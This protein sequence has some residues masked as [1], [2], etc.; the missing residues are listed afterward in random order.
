MKK[1]AI[2]IW[3][4]NLILLSIC[5]VYQKHSELKYTDIPPP[6][7]ITTQQ[8]PKKSV[9]L[10]SGQATIQLKETKIICYKKTDVDMHNYIK[11]H[12]ND[13][14]PILTKRIVK[15]TTAAAKEFNIPREIL[16]S[17]IA[18]ESSFDPE[19][20]SC[21]R[22]IGLTQINSKVWLPELK[23][24]GIVNSKKDLL[25]PEKNIRAGAYVLR[26][27]LDEAEDKNV[28]HPMKYAL[29]RYNGCPTNKY[30]L[31]V[32]NKLKEYINQDA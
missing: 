23:E 15:A 1:Y 11:Y 29:T 10:N 14:D 3:T 18:A 16:V 21:K 17:L 27:Y 13:L 8:I 28:K 9:E 7:V 6:V 26:Y 32:M 4:M 30:Y 5:Y 12:N 2:K 31:T 22:A 20:I 25:N 19:A 24:I